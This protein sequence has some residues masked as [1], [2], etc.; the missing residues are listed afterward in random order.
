MTDEDIDSFKWTYFPRPE[1]GHT[2]IL[3]KND[4][5][6]QENEGR[7]RIHFSTECVK[8]GESSVIRNTF[9]NKFDN[10]NFAVALYS[11]IVISKYH[12]NP[13]L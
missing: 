3:L 8:C 9:S 5:Y 11:F 1:N 10:Y 6:I 12:A 2:V 13:C 7:L 4:A